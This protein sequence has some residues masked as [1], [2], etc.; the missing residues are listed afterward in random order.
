LRDVAT[1]RY[2]VPSEVVRSLAA[3]LDAALDAYAETAS[4]DERWVVG[5]IDKRT[6][7]QR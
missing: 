5:Q 4:D 7:H 6:T 1:E 3:A 2:V